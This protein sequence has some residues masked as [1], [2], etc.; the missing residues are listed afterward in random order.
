M[1]AK[2]MRNEKEKWEDKKRKREK[3]EDKKRKKR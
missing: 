3:W 2:G 1:K